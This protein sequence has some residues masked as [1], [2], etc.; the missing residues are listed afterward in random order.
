MIL[1][2]FDIYVLQTN[3][4][5]VWEV[6]TITTI[7]TIII[8]TPVPS[9]RGGRKMPNPAM[10]TTHSGMGGKETHNFN[11]VGKTSKMT[12]IT[13]TPKIIKITKHD[14]E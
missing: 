3:W 8:I 1:N 4:Q 2:I 7:I 9:A 5:F 6:S 13:K 11:V 12:K 10:T 14:N